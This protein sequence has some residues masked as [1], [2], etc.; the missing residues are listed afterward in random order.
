MTTKNT[1]TPREINKTVLGFR[2][3]GA[4]AY[5]GAENNRKNNR[6][7]RKRVLQSLS[8]FLIS[9]HLTSDYIVF[10][11]ITEKV[12]DDNKKAGKWIDDITYLSIIQ[13]Y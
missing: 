13:R 7:K 2:I 4:V 1:D 11:V 8:I 6:E 3:T 12:T 9:C 10:S 5:A